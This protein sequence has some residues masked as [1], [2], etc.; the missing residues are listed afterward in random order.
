MEI[1]YPKLSSQAVI[2]EL[3]DGTVVL[4]HKTAKTQL[5]LSNEDGTLCRYMTGQL[6][7]EELETSIS[8]SG[9]P[10]AYQE[11]TRILYQLWDRGLLENE[12]EIRNALF[13]GQSERMYEK[14]MRGRSYKWIYSGATK[15]RGGFTSTPILILSG[16]L[17]IVGVLL[18]WTGTVPTD[19]NFFTEISSSGANTLKP[20]QEWISELI[21]I[22]FSAA[23]FLTVRG[24]VRGA[25]LVEGEGIPAILIRWAAGIFYWDVDDRQ[26][27]H[28]TSDKQVRFALGSILHP[29]GIASALGVLGYLSDTEWLHQIALTGLVICF[30]DLC[31][32]FNTSGARLLE[33]IGNLKKQRFRVGSFIQ[34]RMVQS[35]LDDKDY[36]EDKAFRYVATAWILWFFGFIKIFSELVIQQQIE[37]IQVVVNAQSTVEQVVSGLLL[38]YMVL[39]TFA[40][41]GSIAYV[42]FGMI[43][44]LFR[45]T[46]ASKPSFS[47]K[48]AQLSAELKVKL[49]SALRELPML[50]GLSHEQLGQ[51]LD[52]SEELTY[53]KGS[54]VYRQD[55]EDNRF[56][57]VLEGALELQKDLPEGSFKSISLIL[58]DHGVGEEALL[59]QPRAL[60]LKAIEKCRVLSI[61]GLTGL[62]DGKSIDELLN[63]SDSL[64]QFPEMSGL[65]AT[66]KMTLATRS[67]MREFDQGT[68][69][70]QEGENAD[71]LFLIKKG[72][73]VVQKNE[74]VIAEISSGS[75]FGEMGVLFNKPRT[76][77]VLCK[78]DC[79]LIEIPAPALQEAMSRSFHVGLAIETIAAQRSENP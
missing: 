44:Q 35:I 50:A 28:G 11:L 18:Y 56:F 40:L 48:G 45:P 65:S 10:M 55:E 78:T 77:S 8:Q 23:V 70:I 59:R 51:I 38:A 64:E 61:T 41:L 21:V 9:T 68:R 16:L 37:L 17:G 67:A 76:A 46:K 69:V 4:Q 71:S 36:A 29:L 39:L 30:F 62:G 13:P 15:L 26:L 42:V 24:A 25:I 7:L 72:E 49:S 54:W 31:P 66:G 2:E 43:W 60:S 73:V 57:W 34:Q 63:I 22:Y 27:F 74:S 79:E 3:K 20:F 33:S 14:A 6:S 32:F 5:R 52:S 12:D 53:S 58:P 19:E 75:L 47:T 1:I